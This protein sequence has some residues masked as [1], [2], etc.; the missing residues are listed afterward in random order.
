LGSRYIY[1]HKV[2]EPILRIKTK[3][4]GTIRVTK[5]HSLFVFRD[6][7]IKVLPANEIRP[8][9]YIIVAESLPALVNSSTPQI[10]IADL[11]KKAASKHLGRFRLHNTVFL[12]VNDKWIRL[13][14]V[15]EEEIRVA[16]KVRLS[17]SKWI[18]PN[19]ISLDEDVAWLMGIY[20][21]EGSIQKQR[22]LTFNLGIK[23]RNKAEKIAKILS[24]RFG[25]IPEITISERKNQVK[26]VVGSKI[27]FLVLKELGL[28]GRSRDKR[29]PDIIINAPRN[30]LL[31]YLKGLIDGDG[32]IDEYGDIIYSTRSPVLARQVFLLL[33]SL[34][35]NPTLVQNK[36]DNIIRIGKSPF[37]TPPEVYEY[38]TGSDPARKHEYPTEPIYGFPINGK[39]KKE[40]IKLMNNR[41]SSYLSKNKTISK[42]KLR[43]LLDKKLIPD[44]GDY[45]VLANG[46]VVVVKVLSIEEEPYEGYVYDF[47]VPGDNSFIGGYGIIYH[48][49]DPYGWYIYSVFKI[50]SIT[51]SYE[52]ERLAT[53]NAKFIG[54]TMT[55]VFGS[56]IVSDKLSKIRIRDVESITPKKLLSLPPKKPYLSEK[57]RRNFIIKAKVKDVERAV[58]LVGYEVADACLDNKEMRDRIRRKKEGLTGYPWFKTPLWIRELCIFFKTLAKLEIEAMASKGLRF[59]ADKYIPTKIETGDWID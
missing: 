58:E 39:L 32:S 9:D 50:G 46:D 15:T 34:G 4:R 26:V 54:V 38:I 13:R 5:A 2:K 57:E 1:R 18:I 31:A 27:L 35:V 12:H 21:A 47:A 10:I 43:D 29:V 22:Y 51:L 6:G 48:N 24:E 19:R 42:A 37:R 28:L 49:S 11:L 8:G 59:L 45:S 16:D 25:I 53:P 36:D 52:S 3:G 7:K 30:I 41:I 56:D 20:T 23:E 17:R 14:E 33:Q 55:D 40:L 44:I